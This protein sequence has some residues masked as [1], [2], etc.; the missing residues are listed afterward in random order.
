MLCRAKRE[1]AKR[2]KAKRDTAGQFF[3]EMAGKLAR[4]S[5]ARYAVRQ[6]YVACCALRFCEHT[7]AN[8]HTHA[9]SHMHARTR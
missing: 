4:D 8:A 3:S 2:E 7:R 1:K 9:C 6:E 5:C